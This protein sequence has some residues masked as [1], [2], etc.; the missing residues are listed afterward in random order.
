MKI[1]R[2]I[3]E[4]ITEICTIIF[5]LLMLFWL[6]TQMP[7]G[8]TYGNLNSIVF[9]I[10]DIPI[11]KRY[12]ALLFNWVLIVVVV[13]VIYFGIGG[14]LQKKIGAQAFTEEYMPVLV[15]EV[16]ISELKGDA[17]N[18]S[19]NIFARFFGMIEKIISWLLTIPKIAHII[20]TN[21]RVIVVEARKFLW[22]LTW[23][24]TSDSYA[25]KN[26]VKYG[27]AM[28]RSYIFFKS[29]YLTFG[30]HGENLLIKSDQGKVEVDLVN[31]AITKLTS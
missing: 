25:P 29:H 1:L 6:L 11:K 28:L 15:D 8:R 17:Y 14:F 24:V 5:V 10:Y 18:M 9:T 19:P 21:K 20:V 31:K 3:Y 23:N 26:I 30:V 27:Y 16:I 22:F 7:G 12:I 13:N 4:A 2:E